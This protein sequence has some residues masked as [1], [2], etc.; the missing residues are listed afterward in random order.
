MRDEPAHSRTRRIAAIAFCALLCTAPGAAAQDAHPAPVDGAWC[1]DVIQV[2]SA[3][4]IVTGDLHSQKASLWYSR[5]EDGGYRWVGSARVDRRLPEPQ[6]LMLEDHARL[7]ARG[8]ELIAAWSIARPAGVTGPPAFV[9]IS[10]DNGRRWRAGGDAA[11]PA[12]NTRRA[13]SVVAGRAAGQW[14]ALA[15]ATV[16]DTRGLYY[17]ASDDHGKSWGPAFKLTGGAVGDSDLVRAPD[18]M[19]A[20][21][22]AE[23]SG[24]ESTI[25][26]AL[27]LDDGK[28]WGGAVQLSGGGSQA[29]HPRVLVTKE[30]YLA[31]WLEK[32]ENTAR[33]VQR[34]YIGVQHRH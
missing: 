1:F 21:V 6:P 30:G 5:S 2:G 3:I 24:A 18:G 8:R 22:W 19:L 20:A 33:V 4:H 28:S 34:G 23:A 15:R 17:S 10:S 31:L 14:H 25:F 13:Q 26:Y 32:W 9:V 16:E 11:D 27:S 12:V 29:T 7:V